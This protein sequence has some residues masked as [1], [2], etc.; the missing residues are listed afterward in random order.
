MQGQY[1][2]NQQ[3]AQNEAVAGAQARTF[4]IDG[5]VLKKVKNFKYL[6]RQI[7]SRDS[8]ALTLF[9]KPYQGREAPSSNL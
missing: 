3:R 2:T 9:I 1:N 7:S 4:I 5:V 6:G 8:D